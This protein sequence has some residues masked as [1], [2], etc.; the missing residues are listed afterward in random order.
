VSFR[1]SRTDEKVVGQESGKGEKIWPKEEGEEDIK[2]KG[3]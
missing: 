1:L 3:G 2:K